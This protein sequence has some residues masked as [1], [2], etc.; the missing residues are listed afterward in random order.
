MSIDVV[1]KDASIIID[2]LKL[3][4]L[5]K[6]F[7]LPYKFYTT[8]FI[9]NEIIQKDQRMLIDAFIEMGS[10][11][12]IESNT[13]ALDKISEIFNKIK[14]LS[15]ADS[16]VIYFASEMDAIIFTSDNRMR[17]EAENRKIE[18]H[19]ILWVFKEMIGKK[20][21]SKSI[22][23]QKLLKLIKQNMYLPKAE[24]EKCLKDWG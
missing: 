19:G 5:P 10:I 17:K 16:S 8:D 2:L 20:L 21:I 14:K 1:I 4:L 11:S 9:L 23:H 12:I 15:F 3:E 24:C 18:V 6:I 22:A 7:K 13:E